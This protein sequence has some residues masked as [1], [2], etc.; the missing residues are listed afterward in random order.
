M[1]SGGLLACC[2]GFVGHVLAQVRQWNPAPASPGAVLAAVRRCRVR[3]A[4]G[5]TQLSL[6]SVPRAL[7]DFGM[8]GLDAVLVELRFRRVYAHAR[9]HN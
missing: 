1:H 5:N 6:P 3:G 2:V 7:P 8:V 9:D 4:L